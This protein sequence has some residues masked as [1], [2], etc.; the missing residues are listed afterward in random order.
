MS[1]TDLILLPDDP[2]S[3][4]KP[5]LGSGTGQESRF[6]QWARGKPCHCGCS[7][8]NTAGVVRRGFGVATGLLPICL[9]AVVPKCPAC[10]AM[11]VAL[12]TGISL[13]MQTASQLR[14]GM[15]VLGV[16]SLG[17]VYVISRRTYLR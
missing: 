13:S 16:V 14:I 2:Q 10:L 12:G 5:I 1:S 9:L 3:I 4:P 7:Q 6:F 8:R 11:Y 15:I 17:F